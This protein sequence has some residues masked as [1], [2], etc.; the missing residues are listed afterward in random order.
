[1]ATFLLKYQGKDVLITIIDNNGK[2][3]VINGKDVYSLLDIMAN[4]EIKK[5]RIDKDI[6]IIDYNKEKVI[7]ENC[8]CFLQ[9]KRNKSFI[10]YLEGY[11]LIKTEL[12]RLKAKE[13]RYQKYKEAHKENKAVHVIKRV[14]ITGVIL[15]SLIGVAKFSLSHNDL[16]S[17][18]IESYS[19]KS[20]ISDNALLSINYDTNYDA[21]SNTFIKEEYSEIIKKYT[22]RYGIDYNLIKAILNNN[23][24]ENASNGYYETIKNEYEKFVDESIVAYNFETKEPELYVIDGEK[25]IDQDKYIKTICALFQS[26]FRICHNNMVAALQ[27]MNELDKDFKAKILSYAKWKYPEY[28]KKTEESNNY[29]F[30]LVMSD[31]NDYEWLSMFTNEDGTIYSMKVL[32]YLS[33][34]T[35]I[36]VKDINGESI[37]F[38]ARSNSSINAGYII[39]QVSMAAGGNGG[40]SPT[41]ASGGGKDLNKLKEIYEYVEKEIKVEE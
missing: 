17:N 31:Y 36:V 25:L 41:F 11:Q 32:N 1:M 14:S 19:S 27:S 18:N 2:Q 22:E 6:L 29:L 39:K 33:E 24:E 8:E 21:R 26:K 7:I 23:I 5:V 40:G 34:G 20:A 4:K 13:I 12:N 15:T 37:N 9:D 16:V 38:I 35:K 3:K 28:D 10:S 30:E